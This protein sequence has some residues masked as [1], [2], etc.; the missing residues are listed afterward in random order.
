MVEFRMLGIP[1][2][3]VDDFNAIL[4][5]G[6]K[7][8]RTLVMLDLK[9]K[10]FARFVDTAGLCDLRYKGLSFTWCNNQQGEKRVLVRL[11]RALTN[12]EWIH[13]HSRSRVMHL[14]R[15]SSDHA[16]ILVSTLK[17]EDGRRRSFRFELYWAE[18]E[19]CGH[20]VNRA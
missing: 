10:A 5:A 2:I 1:W 12:S 19:K 13:L 7:K 17:G 4:T 8:S 18:Y 16:P 20:I 14:D 6:E 3:V 11:D 9:S 15:S